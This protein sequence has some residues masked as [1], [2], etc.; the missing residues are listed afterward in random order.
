[1]TAPAAKM[2]AVTIDANDAGSVAKFWAELTGTVVTKVEDEGT[3]HFLGSVDSAPELCIQRVA[4]AK[5]GKARVHVD[6]S[7][8][9][10]QALTDR[11]LALGGTWDGEELTMNEY[12]WRMFQDPEG[13]EFDVILE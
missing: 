7:A 11:I 4:E 5:V 6:F 2:I 13:T 8:P 9:D 10:L 12:T 1:V 3:F